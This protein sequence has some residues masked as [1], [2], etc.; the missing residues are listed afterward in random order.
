VPASWRVGR[1]AGRLITAGGI[2]IFHPI[3]QKFHTMQ[4]IARISRMTT[5]VTGEGWR[6]RQNHDLAVELMEK[7]RFGGVVTA[8]MTLMTFHK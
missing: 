6:V 8:D 5:D 4:K 2:H 1:G 7:W 3:N